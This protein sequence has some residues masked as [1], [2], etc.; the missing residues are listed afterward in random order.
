MVLNAFSAI[1]ALVAFA[2]QK[3]GKRM[4]VVCFLD[5]TDSLE[6]KSPEIVNELDLDPDLLR[7]SCLKNLITVGMQLMRHP[8]STVSLKDNERVHGIKGLLIDFR[9]M[10]QIHFHLRHPVFP[11]LPHSQ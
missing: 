7:S 5:C 6:E 3:A 8:E 4:Q 2:F 11:K 1:Q 9:A 10:L